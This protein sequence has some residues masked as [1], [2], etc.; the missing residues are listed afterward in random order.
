MTKKRI[1]LYGV[2][3]TVDNSPDQQNGKGWVDLLNNYITYIAKREYQCFI[4]FN[5]VEITSSDDILSLTDFSD[6]S[7]LAVLSEASLAS[8]KWCNQFNAKD[9]GEK[10]INL[11][12]LVKEPLISSDLPAAISLHPKFDFYLTNTTSGEAISTEDL[13]SPKYLNAFLLKIFDLVKV[14]IESDINPPKTDYKSV[15]LALT[16]HDLAAVRDNVRR[17]L[18]QH[19]YK[20]LPEIAYS[21]M[22]NDLENVMYNDV[23]KCSISVHLI[24]K[25]YDNGLCDT[26][27]SMTEVQYQVAL[28][29]HNGLTKE[30][31]ESECPDFTRVIW[32]PERDLKVEEKQSRFIERFY[33]EQNVL[34]RAEL[35]RSPVEELKDIIIN[36]LTEDLSLNRGYKEIESVDERKSVYVIARDEYNKTHEK[37]KNI[38]QSNEIDVITSDMS[39]NHKDFIGIHKQNLLCCNG[40]LLLA[41]EQDLL[42]LRSKM[43][44]VHKAYSWGRNSAYLGVAVLSA[45]IDQ[46]PEDSTYDQVILIHKKNKFNAG[47][48]TPFTEKLE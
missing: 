37:V 48:L 30:Y 38:L 23:R 33:S 42:W 44:D 19:G 2:Y 6:T 18:I 9:L 20:V 47:I 28:D 7:I 10:S 3:V 41:E 21:R 43:N 32:L 13:L 36:K 35:I 4:E 29:Y 1:K 25:Y 24:G 8:E 34:N 15:Y 12:T 27:L 31:E 39:L 14:L 11:I 40:V 45:S 17:G 22:T 5:K 46:L 26:D 16:S